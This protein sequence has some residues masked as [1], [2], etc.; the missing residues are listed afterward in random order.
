MSFTPPDILVGES[1]QIK[2]NFFSPA[3][4]VWTSSF[5]IDPSERISDSNKGEI[6]AGKSFDTATFIAPFRLSPL[7]KARSTIVEVI[8]SDGKETL[9]FRKRVNIWAQDAIE[10]EEMNINPTHQGIITEGNITSI[11]SLD[12]KQTDEIGKNDGLKIEAK[13]VDT[14]G[15]SDHFQFRWYSTHGRFKT[16]SARKTQWFCYQEE[17]KD[18]PIKATIYS[19]VRDS[20]GGMAWAETQITCH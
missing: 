6:N 7:E 11:K 19:I 20:K 12:K 13:V 4:Q 1:S 10:K 3:D 15:D 2:L 5:V 18:G 17:V 9:K 16:F 8:M 14:P